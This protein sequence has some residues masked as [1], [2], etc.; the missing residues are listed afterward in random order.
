MEERNALAYVLLGVMI[1]AL[2]QAIWNGFGDDEMAELRKEL[3]KAKIAEARANAK[4]QVE[5]ATA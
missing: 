2:V 5:P 1:F 4:T 3:Y